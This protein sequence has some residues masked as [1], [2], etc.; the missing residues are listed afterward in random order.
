MHF[1]VF[2]ISSGSDNTWGEMG[3]E[4]GES[5]DG[6]GVDQVDAGVEI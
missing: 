6:V 3:A 1:E 2:T 4:T 5:T